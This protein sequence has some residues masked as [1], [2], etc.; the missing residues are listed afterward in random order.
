[1]ALSEVE[2]YYSKRDK[3]SQK[4]Q[5]DSERGNLRWT[6][7]RDAIPTLK[8]GESKSKKSLVDMRCGLAAV[9]SICM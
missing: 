2:L 9:K 7:R 8:D 3:Q 4:E 1:M 6:G 5:N